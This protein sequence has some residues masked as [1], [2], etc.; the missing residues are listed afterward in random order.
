MGVRVLLVSD[1]PL[2]RDAVARTLDRTQAVD[3]V[4]T[5]ACAAQTLDCVRELVPDIVLL[6]M[7]MPHALHVAREVARAAYASKIVA[8]AVPEN[9]D[10]VLACAEV[11]AA[12]YVP[13]GGSL[14]CAIE[15]IEAVARGEA[16]CSPRI[17]GSLLRRIA[18][19]AAQRQDDGGKSKDALANLTAREAEILALLRQGLPNKTISRRLGIGLATVKNHV[20]N[21]FAKLGLRSR[22]EAAV[23]AFGA[24]TPNERRASARRAAERERALD[25]SI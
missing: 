22:A 4:G 24:D 15:V 14:G 11:G 7:T 12:G 21:V 6:D 3:V 25:L 19:L 9:E 13:R 23:L 10:D 17:A 2:Y 18:V 1:A 16:H 8:L 5:A 20:H